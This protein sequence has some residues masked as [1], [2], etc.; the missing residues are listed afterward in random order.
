MFVLTA[1]IPF[2][3]GDSRSNLYDADHITLSAAAY[4]QLE[5]NYKRLSIQGGV[6]YEVQKVDND[7]EKGIPVFRSGINFEA[8]K[9]THLR[10]SFG[11][12]Y[13]IPTIGERDILQNF[14]SGILVIPN[15]TLHAEH[16]YSTEIG[17]NQVFKIGKN[18]IG[19]VDFAVYYNRYNQFTE[20]NFGFTKNQ[21]PGSGKAITTDTSLLNNIFGSVK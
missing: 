13:R 14:Y 10:A 12:A 20:L 11:Q 17:I 15:D 1:G 19:F 21:F 16:G 5:F 7:L 2:D 8:S 3:I 4:A 6:R 9:S 18:F